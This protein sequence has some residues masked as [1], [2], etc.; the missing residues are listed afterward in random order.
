MERSVQGVIDE[1]AATEAQPFHRLRIYD[2]KELVETGCITIAKHL[3]S[4]A[5]IKISDQLKRSPVTKN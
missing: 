4:Q 2:I 5:K 1:K 3:E